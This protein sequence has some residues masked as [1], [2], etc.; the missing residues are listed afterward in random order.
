MDNFTVNCFVIKDGT[1]KRIESRSFKSTARTDRGII[2][3]FRRNIKQMALEGIDEND[4]LIFTGTG[5]PKLMIAAYV[6]SGYWIEGQFEG[7]SKVWTGKNITQ[8]D[9][10]WVLDNAKQYIGY[11]LATR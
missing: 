10:D 4:F 6:A 9:I 5:K 8:K 2:A 7:S 11:V 1:P 3:A